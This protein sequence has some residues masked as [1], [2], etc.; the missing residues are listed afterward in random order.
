METPTDSLRGPVS[1]IMFHLVWPFLDPPSV[2]LLCVESPVILCYGNLRAESRSLTCAEIHSIYTPIYQKTS[3]S[4]IC[5][6][7]ARDVFKIM[8]LYNFRLLVMIRCL[9]VVYTRDFL[10]FASIYACLI[11]LSD[12]PVDPG[13]PPHAATLVPPEHPLQS[14]VPKRNKGHNI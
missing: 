12:I 9:G 13:E 1:E 7:Q 4:S 6:R 11:T 3:T 8:I 10:N 5:S 14:F 2:M